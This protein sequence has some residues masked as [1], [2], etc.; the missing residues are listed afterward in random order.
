MKD[1]EDRNW[2]EFSLECLNRLDNCL[3]ETF[4]KKC[5]IRAASSGDLVL[6]KIVTIAIL[7]IVIV[8]ACQLLSV[9]PNHVLPGDT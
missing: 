4:Q 6:L 5:R 9:H 3:K 1:L 2:A 8:S 7:S